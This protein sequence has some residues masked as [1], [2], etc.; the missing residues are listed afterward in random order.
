M[1]IGW[2]ICPRINA[3]GRMGADEDP[4]ANMVI[5]L[6][7]T[8]DPGRAEVLAKQMHNLN[9]ARQ[10]LSDKLFEQA[11]NAIGQNPPSFIVSY[12]ADCPVGVAGL[13]AAK[14]VET[15]RRPTLV[16]N[17]EGRGSGRVPDGE[18]IIPYMEQLTR[19]GI[20]GRQHRTAGGAMVTGVYGGHAGAC[21]FAGVDPQAM[22]SAARGL[23]GGR[24]VNPPLGIEARMTLAELTPASATAF[25]AMGPFG[26]GNNEPRVG[27][28]GLKVAEVAASKNG[29]HLFLQV[30]DGKRTV[31]AVWFGSG[32]MVGKVPETVDICG[33]PTINDYTGQPQIQVL[34]VRA[35]A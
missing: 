26:V 29:K 31:R 34:D 17:S 30:T 32:N 4:Y 25:E 10:R 12:L 24:A 8:S 6:L 35:A 18:N 14:L 13:V 15:Y 22:V 20:F 9:S 27:F 1:D 11:T 19:S 21:G 5:E 33:Y 7:S 16:V 23:S 28:F 2:K 3:V